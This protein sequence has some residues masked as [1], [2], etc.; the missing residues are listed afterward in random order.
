M[1]LLVA[2]LAFTAWPPLHNG[3]VTNKKKDPVFG[4]MYHEITAINTANACP[5]HIV[6]CV[7]G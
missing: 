3:S 5:A 4:G 2:Q 7:Q 6:V 1:R